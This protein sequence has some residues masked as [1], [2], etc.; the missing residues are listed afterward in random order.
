MGVPS[1]PLVIV[2]RS[3]ARSVGRGLLQGTGNSRPMSTWSKPGNF[4]CIVANSRLEV[5]S[6]VILTLRLRVWRWRRSRVD[7]VALGVLLAHWTEPAGG[8]PA[9]LAQ[10]QV[11][12]AGGRRLAEH[13][14]GGGPLERR[15]LGVA[16]DQRRPVGERHGEAA[17]GPG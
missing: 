9:G 14:H 10:V 5:E 8:D 1:G 16:E 6:R 12:G 17:T 11:G 13:A 15:L 4:R 3:H 7:G 2:E